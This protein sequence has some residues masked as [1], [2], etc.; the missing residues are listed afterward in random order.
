[1][2]SRTKCRILPIM[3]GTHRLRM[4]RMRATSAMTGLR[5]SDLSSNIELATTFTTV[6]NRQSLLEVVRN[7][8]ELPD[9]PVCKGDP[10]D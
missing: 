9:E 3:T 2:I 8:L 5:A 4:D 7:S 6:L 1:M 10:K